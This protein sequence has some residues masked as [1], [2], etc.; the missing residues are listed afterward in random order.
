M[1]FEGGK[2]IWLNRRLVPWEQA[3]VHVL[4]HA[5]HYGSSVFEGIRV[6]KTPDGPKVFRLMDHMQRLFDSAK[7]YRLPIPYERDELIAACKEVVLA[8]ELVNGA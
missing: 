7:I 4:S 8:N 6:Y 1:S 3:T 2:L 5:L